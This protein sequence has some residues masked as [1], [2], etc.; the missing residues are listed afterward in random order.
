MMSLNSILT[1]VTGIG[2]V[3]LIPGPTNTL[4][5]V[6]GLKNGVVKALP[7]IIAE[8]CGYTAAIGVWGLSLSTIPVGVFWIQSIIKALCS[9]YIFYLATKVWSYGRNSYYEDN[10]SFPQMVLASSLNPKAL[11]FVSL[12]IPTSSF[13]NI[14]EFIF[15][16]LIFT[17]LLI[18]I[19][20]LWISLGGLIRRNPS[21]N[22]LLIIYKILAVILI[23]F[24]CVLFLSI[25]S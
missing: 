11:L 6:S 7:L 19:G 16:T 21:E 14:N 25:F 3:L 12:F 9:F 20:L 2:F 1:M 15:F 13:D 17:I 22:S 23:A 24:S 4:L 10:I 8:A 18:P 5:L